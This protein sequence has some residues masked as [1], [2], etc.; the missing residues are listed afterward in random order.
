MSESR[1]VVSPSKHVSNDTLDSKERVQD[2]IDTSVS[3]WHTLSYVTHLMYIYM[4]HTYMY[5]VY[6]YDTIDTCVSESSCR[7][8]LAV[9]PP[10]R[11]VW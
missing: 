8:D 6:V 7:L 1:R 11:V 3:V 5:Q 4:I 2:V 9:L 10:Y